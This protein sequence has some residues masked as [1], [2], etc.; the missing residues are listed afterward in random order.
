MN[1]MQLRM[2][3]R[4][5]E[6]MRGGEPAN[7]QWIGPHLSQRMFGITEKR[8][9]AYAEAHGGEAKKMEGEE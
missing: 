1:D 8:A 3:R 2:F 7:W 4:L 6:E 5:A 9:K